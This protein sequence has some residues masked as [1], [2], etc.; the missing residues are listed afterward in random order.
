MIRCG[1][2]RDL[3]GCA[4]TG[5]WQRRVNLRSSGTPGRR[6]TNPALTRPRRSRGLRRLAREAVWTRAGP[7]CRLKRGRL[8]RRWWGGRRSLKTLRRRLWHLVL[9][10]GWLVL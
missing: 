4:G 6:S 10:S 2:I 8:R 5:I 1:V 3:R 9:R 7:V